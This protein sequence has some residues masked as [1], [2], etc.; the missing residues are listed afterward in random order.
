MAD[1][2][3]TF[4]LKQGDAKSGFCQ[5]QQSFKAQDL[6]KELGRGN[7]DFGNRLTDMA[8]SGAGGMEYLASCSRPAQPGKRKLEDYDIEKQRAGLQF[9][10]QQGREGRDFGIQQG[11][12]G[13]DFG[14]NREKTV[15]EHLLDVEQHRYELGMQQ[16]ELDIKH[17]QA[18]EDSTTNLER[19]AQDTAIGRQELANKKSDLTQDT[20]MTRNKMDFDESEKR[21]SQNQK[22]MDFGGNLAS[23]LP[24]GDLQD[25]MKSNPD[26]G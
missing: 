14:Q 11:R 24:A 5:L 13:R 16:L 12:E 20:Q 2:N 18:L 9:G 19:L 4:Q 23:Q 1:E 25:L 6:A 3:Q 17:N 26:T 10:I 8:I 15:K 7:R 22:E 21:R